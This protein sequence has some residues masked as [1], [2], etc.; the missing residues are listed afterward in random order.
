[1]QSVAHGREHT[2]SVSAS[3]ARAKLKYNSHRGGNMPSEKNI[4]EIVWDI[5]V[6]GGRKVGEELTLELNTLHEV[7]VI[8]RKRGLEAV[9]SALTDLVRHA[10]ECDGT[11]FEVI[12]H[13]DAASV[14]CGHALMRGALWACSWG[15]LKVIPYLGEHNFTRN[16]V[17]ALA[18][19]VE[20]AQGE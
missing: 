6:T 19:G 5:A 18:S 4:H 9:L 14:A 8:L 16:Y 20:D 13:L 1:M 3:T 2:T 12:E 15:M 7:S 17:K 10:D 11:D